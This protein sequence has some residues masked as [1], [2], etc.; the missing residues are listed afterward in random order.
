MGTQIMM[1]LAIA[2]LFPAVLCPPSGAYRLAIEWVVCAGTAAAVLQAFRERH[3]FLLY[4]FLLVG[5]VFNPILPVPFSPGAFVW[6]AIACTAAFL[7]ALAALGQPVPHYASDETAPSQ[8]SYI[9]RRMAAAVNPRALKVRE[10]CLMNAR[11][12]AI[13]IS[14]AA[15]SAAVLCVFES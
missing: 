8:S 9:G 5:V 3:R 4:A 15:L 14:S 13:A 11:T 2:A 10:S 12:L 1:W 6:L 7:A